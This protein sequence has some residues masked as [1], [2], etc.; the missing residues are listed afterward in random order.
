[1]ILESGYKIMTS[2]DPCNKSL[3]I[4]VGHSGVKLVPFIFAPCESSERHCQID[5]YP[6]FIPS[7]LKQYDKNVAVWCR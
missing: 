6:K 3:V 4:E 7:L 5:S 2:D 1:M